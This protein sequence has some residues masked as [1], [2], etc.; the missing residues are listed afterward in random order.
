MNEPFQIE[1]EMFLSIKNWQTKFPRLVAGFTTRNGGSSEKPYTCNNMGLHVGDREENVICNR[2]KLACKIDMPLSHWVCCQQTHGSHIH[3]I[4]KQDAGKGATQFARGIADTDG[5]YTE[6]KGML[7][8]L[9]YADCVPIFFY[10]PRI[11]R[12]GIAHAGWRGTVKN[13]G[14]A[15]IEQWV[16]DGIQPEEIFV[17]I[18]PAICKDCYIVDQKVIDEVEKLPVDVRKYFQEISFNQFSLDLKELNRALLQKAGVPVENILVSQFCTSCNEDLFFSHRRDAKQTGR[19]G[20]M[21]GF[22]GMK[23]DTD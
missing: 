13:I 5:L 12:A 18:G 8:V 22:I 3:A 21:I 10:A 2:K 15:M 20:R 9:A 23:E 17:A 1:N 7:L 6:E 19:T 4:K 11:E 14:L 16:N